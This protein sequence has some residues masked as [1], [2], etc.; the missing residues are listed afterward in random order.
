[1]SKVYKAVIY[2]DDINDM[3]NSIENIKLELENNVED[4]T[5][6]FE[7][8]LESIEFL[9]KSVPINCENRYYESVGVCANDKK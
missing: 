1:M 9:L 6:T 8:V 4:L 7:K 2:I 3:F 5:F